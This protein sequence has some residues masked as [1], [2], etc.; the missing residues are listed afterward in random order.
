M[1]LTHR[2]AHGF[3]LIWVKIQVILVLVRLTE[4]SNGF[5]S[6]WSDRFIRAGLVELWCGFGTILRFSYDLLSLPYA[7][8]LIPSI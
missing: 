1:V 3:S 2:S 6:V 8:R 5:N 4:I 7:T